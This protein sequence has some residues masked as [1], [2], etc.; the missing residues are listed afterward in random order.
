[1]D[2]AMRW[3]TIALLLLAASCASPARQAVPAATEP[4][5][6]A[7]ARM[8]PSPSPSPKPTTRP[9][10]SYTVVIDP[11]HNGGNAAHSRE[12]NQPVDAVTLHKPCDTTG[13]ATDD[14]YSES[15]FNFDVSMRLASMLRRAGVRVI[16]TRTSDTGWGPCITERAAIGNRNDADAALSIH[17][18]GGPPSGYGFHVIEPGLVRGYTDPIVGP[19]RRLGTDIRDAYRAGTGM[20]YATY[21]GQNGIDVRT[22]LGGLNLSKVP[23]VFVECGNMRNE[24][25]ARQLESA[26]FR[27][28]IA[29][30]LARGISAF[31]SG[32]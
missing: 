18:D 1:M 21:L 20:S 4:A 27:A 7:P 6:T 13:T 3:F 19:S 30:A 15:A 29:A 11:G 24:T 5:A 26:A 2:A 9:E 10:R 12:I 22:D 8:S 32:R 25:D 14:G 17:A 16:L 31:L 28:R 23:K